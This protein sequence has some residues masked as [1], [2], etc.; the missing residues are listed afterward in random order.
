MTSC[1]HVDFSKSSSGPKN[2]WTGQLIGFGKLLPV[3]SSIWEMMG[4]W[5]QYVAEKKI[6][7]GMGGGIGSMGQ[8]SILLLCKENT[9]INRTTL[10]PLDW[11]SL[12]YNVSSK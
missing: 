6:N 3:S 5:R 4:I 2:E 11:I 9:E 8:D 10:I 12:L 1:E 7:V